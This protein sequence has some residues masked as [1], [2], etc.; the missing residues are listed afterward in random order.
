MSSALLTKEVCFSRPDCTTDAGWTGA[1]P[2]PGRR[3][4]IAGL[5]NC[6]GCTT[7]VGPDARRNRTMFFVRDVP[8]QTSGACGAGGAALRRA[9]PDAVRLRSPATTF[10]GARWCMHAGVCGWTATSPQVRA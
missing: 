9:R 3:G 6:T 8:T 7:R 1:A 2:R 4:L 5:T 10:I